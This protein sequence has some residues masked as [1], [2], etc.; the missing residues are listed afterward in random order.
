[1]AYPKPLS[2]ANI[3]KLFSSWDPETVNKLHTYYE[4]FANLYGSVQLKEAWKVFK[5]FEPKIHKKQFIA[6][7]DIVR[8]ED[9]PYYIFEIDELYNEEKR[10]DT[11]RFIVKKDLVLSGYGKNRFVYDLNERQLGKPYYDKPDLIDAAQHP[12][13]DKSLKLFIGKM[14]F[15]EGDNKG[16]LFSEL[17]M[18]DHEEKFSLDYYSG[19]Q[20]KAAILKKADIPFSEKLYTR[21]IWNANFSLSPLNSILNYLDKNGFVFESMEQADKF[22][23]L[24]TDFINKSHLWCNCGYSPEKLHSIYYGHK[25]T[26]PQSVSFGSGI[27][28]AFADE[29]IDKDEVIKKLKEMGIE[30]IE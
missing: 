17:Y 23:E 13:Y 28:Q 22:V 20:K 15:T 24:F 6:F 27:Q 5:K 2:K 25:N 4:A 12:F 9:V 26:M 16:K 29:T 1:M 30:V 10:I 11:E 7:S 18:L 19:K 3:L 21:I 8:R 14:K